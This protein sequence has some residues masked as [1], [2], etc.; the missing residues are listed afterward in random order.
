VSI[1]AIIPARWGSSRLPGKVALDLCGRSMLEHVWRGVRRCERLREVLVATDDDRIV[2]LCESFGARAI[3]TSG[4]HPTGTDR[5]AEVAEGLCDDI[6]VNVQGDEPLMEP[7]VIEVALDALAADPDAAMSTVV[8]AADPEALADPNRVKVVCDRRG[9]ALY[10]SR[11]PIPAGRGS[12]PAKDVWQHVG[13][14]AYRRSFLLDYVDLERGA[15]EGV[16]GL[17]QLRALEHGHA[18][19]VGRIDGWRS[20]P[21]D[22]PDDV[23]AVIRALETLAARTAGAPATR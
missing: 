15:L 16:E 20:L 23:P 21:V 7:R 12:G 18:V 9:R 2:R 4:A 8:H 11:A 14:Y 6:V 17:E 5:I 1:V 10:F 3:L 13:L 19:A 22:V